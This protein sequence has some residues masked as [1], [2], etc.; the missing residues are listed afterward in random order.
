M[1]LTVL[2]LDCLN[3]YP[4]ILTMCTDETYGADLGIV[5]KLDYKS[6]IIPFDIAGQGRS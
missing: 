4:V 3:I 1:G 5:M 6:I 2:M